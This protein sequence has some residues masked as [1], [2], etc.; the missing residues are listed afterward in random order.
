M[1]G[2]PY[3]DLL[4]VLVVS[5][6]THARGSKRSSFDIDDVVGICEQVFWFDF[7]L[8]IA[9]A[10][11]SLW[12]QLKEYEG[13]GLFFSKLDH[14]HRRLKYGLPN[15]NCT[16][17]FDLGFAERQLCINIDRVAWGNA[18]SIDAAAEVVR[19]YQGEISPIM[20]KAP[21]YFRMVLSNILG[22]DAS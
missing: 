11:D 9:A 6:A 5:G 19:E 17:Y 13:R 21:A 14:V 7:P 4:D 15:Q 2:D 18:N 22:A 16:Y 10:R 1:E 20:S 3:S 8:V 12:Q